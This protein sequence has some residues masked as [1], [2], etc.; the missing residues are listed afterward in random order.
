[1]YP[2]VNNVI[3]T[4][5]IVAL[6]DSSFIRYS[7]GRKIARRRRTNESGGI[8]ENAHLVAVDAVMQQS[9]PSDRQ[10]A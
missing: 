3:A 5:V 8:F 9:M 7:T 2:N 4:S 1:M 6:W 10:F